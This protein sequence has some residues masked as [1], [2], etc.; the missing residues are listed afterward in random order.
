MSLSLV[1]M[2]SW[3][4]RKETDFFTEI[5]LRHDKKRNTL[6]ELENIRGDCRLEH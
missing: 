2:D 1:F 5:Q 3:I 4:L 6:K